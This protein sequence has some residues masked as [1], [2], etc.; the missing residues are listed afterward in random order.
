MHQLF[1]GFKPISGL[2]SLQMGKMVIIW[3]GLPCP[4]A[5][6]YLSTTLSVG[7]FSCCCIKQG[8]TTQEIPLEPWIGVWVQTNMILKL[9]WG[10]RVEKIHKPYQHQPLAPKRLR[11]ETFCKR[12]CWTMAPPTA[13]CA[14]CEA[15]SQSASQSAGRSTAELRC[16]RD[17]A[18]LTWSTSEPDILLSLHHSTTTQTDMAG[19]LISRAGT[20]WFA[21]CSL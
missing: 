6:M 19:P 20:H 15:D 18:W 10:R 11:S 16:L 9:Y 17:N 14:G 3:P 4:P 5:A 12:D 1:L 7:F 2:G 21:L 8:E 13:L